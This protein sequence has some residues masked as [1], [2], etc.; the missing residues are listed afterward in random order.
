MSRIDRRQVLTRG[1]A[2]G[3]LGVGAASLGACSNE[4]RG[5]ATGQ[6]DQDVTLP[7]YM[8]Y[9]GVEPSFR[10]ENGVDDAAVA[11]PKNPVQ[12]T[13]GQPG[14]GNTIT[15]LAMTNTPA[16]PG[17]E[18]NAFWQELHQ[19]IGCELKIQLV[20]SADFSQR[21]QTA[22]AGDKLPDLFTMFSG[23][24][25]SM[26]GVLDSQAVDLT[27][28]LAGDAIAKYPMLANIPTASWKL[29]VYGGKIFGIP[30]P[31]GAQS[32]MTLYGRRDLLESEGIT[33]RPDSL[34]D[35]EKLCQQLTAGRA[36]TWALGRLPMLWIRQAFGIANNWSLQDGKLIS[37]LE[38]EHQKDA[39]EAARRLVAKG[40]VHP[41]FPTSSG[42]IRKT[43]MVNGNILLVDDTFSGWP[44]FYLYPVS[45]EFRLLT[46]APPSEDGG[47]APIWLERPTYS[48]TAIN[49]LAAD[50]VEAMLSFINYLAAPFGTEEYLFKMFGVEGTHYELDGTDPVLTTKGKSETQLSLQYLGQGPWTVYMPGHPEVTE[51]AFKAQSKL[52]PSAL[53]DPTMGLY[54]ETNTRLSDQ[55]GLGDIE[56]D[57]LQGRQPVNKWD[58]A[59]ATWKSK[60]GDKIRDEYQAALD[61]QAT[62]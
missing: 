61:E 9:D 47:D 18:N 13:D 30:I 54:S 1:L 49:K 2:I 39:L 14:D 32:S 37:A 51:D 24:V 45:D 4:G 56:N 7:T 44:G 62:N 3:A 25:P 22:V 48:I 55:I 52:V 33:G 38:H 41:D 46:W 29:S 20:P 50:R 40:V 34:P 53:P 27:P 16:P 11:F 43:W 12:A 6:S 59:V 31:R 15:A 26:P 19:R 28:H 58:D 36:N 17:V 35:F 42:S 57:I 23:G 10:G 5:G 60:G 8:R 21:F